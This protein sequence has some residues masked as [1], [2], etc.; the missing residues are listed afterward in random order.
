MK[1]HLQADLLLKEVLSIICAHILN[2]LFLSPRGNIRPQKITSSRIL[3]R[4]GIPRTENIVSTSQRPE[5][6]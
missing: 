3:N 2:D 6:S 1:P 5:L 4:E